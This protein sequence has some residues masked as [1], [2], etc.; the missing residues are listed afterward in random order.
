MIK[1]LSSFAATYAI[2]GSLAASRLAAVAPPRLAM[3]Y[4][5]NIKQAAEALTLLPAESGANVVLIE[6]VDDIVFERTRTSDRLILV[7]PSQVFTDLL[8]SPGR[9]PA[10]AEALITWMRENQESWRG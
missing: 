9:G 1:R 7:A 2:T 5:E 3:L 4:I 6:P 10:E 8:D